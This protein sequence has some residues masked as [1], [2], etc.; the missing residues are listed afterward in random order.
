M[1]KARYI[2]PN[3]FTSVNFLFGVWAILFATGALE[4]PFASKI[5]ALLACHLIIYCVLMDKL[6]GFA[7][8]IMNAR[9]QFGA[10]F[11]SLADLIAFGIA[12]AIC[13]LNAYQE[14]TP[15][16]Y[17][18]NKLFLLVSVSAYVLCAAMR[19]AR[20][21]AVD[22]DAHPDFF[23]GL[24]TTLAGGF[25]A[26]FLAIAINYNFFNVEN[27]W[28]PVLAIF[29]MLSAL[30]MVSRLFLPKF[31]ARKNK[32]LN[33]IQFLGIIVGYSLG[34]AMIY[35]EVLLALIS[36]YAVVG[37]SYGI[38]FRLLHEDENN[39]DISDMEGA[40]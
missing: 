13:M 40:S 23:V 35:T 1:N 28:M 19:L 14:F 20:Y 29:M 25:N 7:A 2:V 12:P 27:A 32:T 9:S 21:N 16:W 26:V 10:Q 17:E 11:D 33:V 30:L 31:K 39:S 34:F 6:D 24:P 4:S 37:F 5:S 18:D 38:I 8:S 3:F 22:S 15:T 36:V